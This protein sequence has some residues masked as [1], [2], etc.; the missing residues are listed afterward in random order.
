M[1]TQATGRLAPAML[2]GLEEPV[3]ATF[4]TRSRRARW[5]ARDAPVD[6]RADRRAHLAALPRRLT[7]PARGRGGPRPRRCGPPASLLPARAVRWHAESDEVLA[8][9]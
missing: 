8:H 2:D 4:S 9:R 1:T 5:W 3:R 7:R 6:D